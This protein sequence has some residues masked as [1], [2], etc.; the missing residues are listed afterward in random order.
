MAMTTPVISTS[1]QT[2]DGNE[3]KKMSFVMPSRYWQESSLS[4]A[5][6]PVEGGVQLEPFSDAKKSGQFLAA[7]WFGGYCTQSDVDKRVAEMRKRIEEDASWEVVGG[8]TQSP[9]VL[10]YNDPFQPPWKRR[11][12]V[13]LVVT[14]K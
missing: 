10:Q 1:T 8:V 3:Q 11:N 9:L 7:C 4:S 2:T 13:C 5:P 14:K 6:A 12:E